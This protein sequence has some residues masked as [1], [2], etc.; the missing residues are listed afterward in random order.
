MIPATG[1]AHMCVTAVG[2]SAIAVVPVAADLQPSLTAYQ[3]RSSSTCWLARE[4]VG[5]VVVCGVEGIAPGEALSSLVCWKLMSSDG[6][7]SDM[8]MKGRSSVG[9]WWPGCP[10]NQVGE[11]L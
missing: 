5:L 6:Q 8:L 3:G 11:T 4:G 2:I 9:A 1:S 7:L 10:D